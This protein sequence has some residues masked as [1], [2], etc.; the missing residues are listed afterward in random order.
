MRCWMSAASTDQGATAHRNFLIP[1]VGKRGSV[2]APLDESGHVTKHEH[3]QTGEVWGV[4][5]SVIVGVVG[6]LALVVIIALLED[7]I[8]SRSSR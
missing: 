8:R 7:E 2:Y 4:A 3:H 5:M 1:D 6:G